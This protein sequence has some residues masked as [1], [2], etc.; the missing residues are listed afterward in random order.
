MRPFAPV[1]IGAALFLAGTALRAEAPYTPG[2][3]VPVPFEGL[4]KGFLEKHCVECHDDTTAEADLNLLD[5][6]PVDETNAAVW[7]SV[8]AQVA[9]REM[10][11]EK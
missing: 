6:G 4:A 7:K 5:L 3:P 1:A 2:E 9:L 10:P 11:P 8:W